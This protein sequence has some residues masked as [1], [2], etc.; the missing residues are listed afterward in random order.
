MRLF[1]RFGS[2]PLTEERDKQYVKTAVLTLAEVTQH[3]TCGG[4]H[5]IGNNQLGL[6]YSM[7]EEGVG[8]V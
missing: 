6:G 7:G 4:Y 5:K 8:G 2:G 3:F 1:F